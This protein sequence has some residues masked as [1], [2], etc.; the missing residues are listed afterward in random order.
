MLIEKAELT[1][2]GQTQTLISHL[3]KNVFSWITPALKVLAF[4][5]APSFCGQYMYF[6]CSDEERKKLW[7]AW[8]WWVNREFYFLMH[9]SFNS[10]GY[11]PQ[12]FYSYLDSFTVSCPIFCAYIKSLF[13]MTAIFSSSMCIYIYTRATVKCPVLN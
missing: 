6:M 5:K 2:T 1:E 9:C 13:M 12:T 10:I 4:L 7:M 8:G 3:C 11:Y